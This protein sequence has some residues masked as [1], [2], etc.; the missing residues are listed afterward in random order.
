MV[1]RLRAKKIIRDGSGRI[2]EGRPAAVRD[3]PTAVIHRRPALRIID[4]RLSM[5]DD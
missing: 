5:V 3:L 1:K 2:F 4:H